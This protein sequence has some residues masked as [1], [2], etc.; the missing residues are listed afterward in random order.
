[1]YLTRVFRELVVYG[2]FD[3]LDASVDKSFEIAVIKVESLAV[4]CVLAHIIQAVVLFKVEDLL[5]KQEHLDEPI[6]AE[7]PIAK[8]AV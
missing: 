6:F 7:L 5:D 3:T 8:I 2:S 1:M 4:E